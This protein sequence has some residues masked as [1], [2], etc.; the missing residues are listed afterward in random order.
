MLLG[1]DGQLSI[2][3]AVIVS[4]AAHNL[5]DGDCRMVGGRC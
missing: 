3:T 4:Y 1:N 2:V 5:P